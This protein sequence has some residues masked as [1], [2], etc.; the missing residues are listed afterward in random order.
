MS[1]SDDCTPPSM[2]SEPVPT[3][4]DQ[5]PLPQKGEVFWGWHDF[6]L[7]AC[8]TV[9]SLGVAMLCG[10]G[11]RHLFHLSEARM[12][13]VFVIAQFTA[14]GVAFTC[15]KLMFRA[16]YGEPLMASLGWLPT[17][18]DPAKLM[19]I[20]LGQAFAIAF[21]G[22]FMKVPNPDTP[23]NRLLADRPTA[24]VIAILGVTIAPLAEELAFRGLLQP[25]LI[26]TV[27]VVPGILATAMLFGAMHLEQYG[28]WQSVVLITL[29]GV[30][31]GCM[32]YWTGSTRASALMHAGYNS[33][34]FILFFAQKAPHG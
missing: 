4:F 13:I 15:L 7:F 31:F 8:L 11:I 27:G 29:A 5:A 9:L 14:Y 3:P 1:E 28:A 33:A 19:L 34:L 21:I 16:E 20:G 12:N 25:L 26:R 10:M 22:A 24:I 23:M 32:R 30:G 2:T 18:I 6:V 17:G